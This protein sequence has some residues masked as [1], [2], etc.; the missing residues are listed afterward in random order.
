MGDLPEIEI[1][2]ELARPIDFAA[3]KRDGI[4]PIRWIAQPYLVEQELN[5]WIGDGFTAKSMLA[6]DTAIGLAAGSTI[7]FGSQVA[8]AYRVLYMD[9]D[10]GLAQ[11]SRRVLQLAKGRGL[12]DDE[13]MFA[14]LSVFTQVG[15]SLGGVKS[16]KNLREHLDYYKPEILILDALRAFHAYDEN[17]SDAMA[18]LMRRVIRPL[19]EQHGLSSIIMLHHTAKDTPGF[20]GKSASAASRGS[21]EIRNAP[22]ITLHLVRI[23]NV[24]TV[25]MEKARNLSEA[26]RPGPMSFRIKDLGGPD[27]GIVVEIVEDRDRLTKVG[28]AKADILG[29]LASN[30]GSEYCN[31]DMERLLPGVIKGI[32]SK[33]TAF[34]ALRSMVGTEL[35]SRV[36]PTGK[37]R[38]VYRLV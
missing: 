35:F 31:A 19:I 16:I 38:V 14:N 27:D 10:G 1:E 2:R 21:T 37:K 26:D 13:A 9:E 12:W 28:L 11:T 3:L 36:E 7:L 34:S 6:L 8:R 18:H 22:D 17:Q 30:P 25:A 29:F 33:A 24:P 4:P 20:R 32:Y 5:L 15:F 23:R